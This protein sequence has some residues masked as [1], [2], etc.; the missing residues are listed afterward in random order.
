[1]HN[2]LLKLLS[3]Q[4][5]NDLLNKYP[6]KATVEFDCNEDEVTNTFNIY[7]QFLAENKFKLN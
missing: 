5:L 1:M 4:G 7:I 6:F 3:K 2:T